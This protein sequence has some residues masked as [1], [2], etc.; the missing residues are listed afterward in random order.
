[1]PQSPLADLWW[2]LDGLAAAVDHHATHLKRAYTADPSNLLLSRYEPWDEEPD[3]FR[4][5]HDLLAGHHPQYEIWLGLE[6]KNRSA[7]MMLMGTDQLVHELNSNNMPVV[8]TLDPRYVVFDATNHLEIICTRQ[9]RNQHVL[10][11]HRRFVTIHVRCLIPTYI[12]KKILPP[13]PPEGYVLDERMIGIQE[14]ILLA[15]TPPPSRS[16]APCVRTIG[17]RMKRRVGSPVRIKYD[18][19]QVIASLLLRAMDLPAAVNVTESLTLDKNDRVGDLKG[20]WKKKRFPL[21]CQRV[22]E[23]GLCAHGGNTL[24]CSGGGPAIFVV[25]DCR[26]DF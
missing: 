7:K 19:Y 2:P 9:K 5:F 4:L 25:D 17:S 18:E 16:P 3:M 23:C 15:F 14:R 1:M 20:L 13:L 21:R 26:M 12:N 22:A 8:R 6:K 11:L 10:K 24:A